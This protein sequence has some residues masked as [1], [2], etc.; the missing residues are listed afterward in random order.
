MHEHWEVCGHAL[1]KPLDFAVQQYSADTFQIC[2]SMAVHFLHIL[3]MLLVPHQQSGL[4]GV[5]SAQ[6]EPRIKS[7]LVHP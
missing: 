3:L 7:S 2:C 4:G 5:R 1:Q 6:H